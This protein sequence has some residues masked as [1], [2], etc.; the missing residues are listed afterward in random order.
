MVKHDEKRACVW[1][2]KQ[3]FGMCPAYGDQSIRVEFYHEST[4]SAVVNPSAV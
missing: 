4:D 2:S 1:V 3:T